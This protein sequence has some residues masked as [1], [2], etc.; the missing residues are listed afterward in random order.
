MNTGYNFLAHNA[1][2][3]WRGK[4][5]HSSQNPP[6]ASIKSITTI[7][8]EEKTPF[9]PTS[10]QPF[11]L[12]AKP[13]HPRRGQRKRT[14]SSRIILHPPLLYCFKIKPTA[15]RIN[16][17]PF[18]PFYITST[19]CRSKTDSHYASSRRGLQHPHS[20]HFPLLPPKAGAKIGSHSSLLLRWGLKYPH[21]NLKKLLFT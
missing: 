14:H 1:K 12:H 6:S 15:G 11:L 18:Q 13:T 17:S 20:S 16:G 5:P 7:G 3:I 8:G 4:K 2:P 21:S 19:Q 10:L 9:Q